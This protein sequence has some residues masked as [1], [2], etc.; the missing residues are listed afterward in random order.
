M[1][2]SNSFT[3]VALSWEASPDPSA[4]VDSL[5]LPVTGVLVPGVALG[6]AEA[7]G[8]CDAETLGEGV[9]AA[10]SLLAPTAWPL[11]ADEEGL[12]DE[13]A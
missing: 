10:L 3:V 1:S 9:D 6:L 8:E 13:E 11:P 12:A 5:G 2:S 7:P 4:V